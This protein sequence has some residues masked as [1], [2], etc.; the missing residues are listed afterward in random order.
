ML[1]IV[2]WT[3]FGAH[4]GWDG[5]ENALRQ[6]KAD[7]CVLSEVSEEV[8]IQASARSFGQGHC[9]LRMSNPAVVGRG[10]VRGGKWLQREGGVKA[11]G[12]V[13]TSPQGDCRVPVM[14]LAAGV[15]LAGELRLTEVRTLMVDWGVDIVVGD[16][17]A[18][19]RSWAL[20]LL[21]S[22][23]VHAYEAAGSAS[24]PL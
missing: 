7:I 21:P 4:R 17:N 8:D 11:H 1:R 18:P 12:V 13:W 22:G 14:D 16:S 23:F 3:V 15:L 2:R 6:R 5:V 10:S 20:S 24:V 9:A 19:W